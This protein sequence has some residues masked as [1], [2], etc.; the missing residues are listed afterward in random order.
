[1]WNDIDLYHAV[2]DFT[3]DPVSFPAAE[4]RAFTQELVCLT[5]SRYQNR[6]LYLPYSPRLLNIS[7]TFQ[8]SMPLWLNK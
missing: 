4:M 6:K 8:L 3:T 7:I 1:M 2:R 5:L